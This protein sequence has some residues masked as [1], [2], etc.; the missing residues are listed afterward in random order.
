M[1]VTWENVL[2]SVDNL[3]T[4]TEI[5]HCNSDLR[6]HEAVLQLNR[7]EMAVSVLRATV[8]MNLDLDRNVGQVLGQ[9]C[10]LLSHIYQ[11]SKNPHTRTPIFGSG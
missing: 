1:E 7:L 5:Q 11:Y 4:E 3:L 8:D 6:F 2:S 9:L 10:G